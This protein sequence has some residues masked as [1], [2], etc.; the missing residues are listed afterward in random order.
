MNLTGK[1]SEND[2]NAPHLL[3]IPPAQS[4]QSFSTSFKSEVPFPN[5]GRT[6]EERDFIDYNYLYCRLYLYKLKNN[7]TT[8]GEVI[9]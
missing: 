6:T 3:Y 2:R 5:P 1:T 4:T 7:E 9:S 8:K